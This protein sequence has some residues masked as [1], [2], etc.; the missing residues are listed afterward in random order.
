[1]K[2][3]KTVIDSH[4]HLFAVRDEDGK[5]YFEAFDEYQQRFGLKAI[6]ICCCTICFDDA[7]NN[8]LAALYKL[9][10]PTAF[11][12]GSLVYS[13]LPVKL[14]VPKGM[15]AAT[16]YDE[17]R[18]IGFDGIKLIETKPSELKLVDLP[19]NSKF[20]DE[21]FAKAEQ[22]GTH[23]IWHV[24]DPQTNWDINTVPDWAVR[25]GWYYGD[26]TYPTYE[27]IYRQVFDVLE[28]YPRLNVTFAHFFFLSDYPEELEKI[29]ERFPNVSIDLVP[30]SEM[31]AGINKQHERYR[32]FFEK[33]ADRIVYGTDITFLIELWN[34]DHL[35]NEVYKAVATDKNIEIYSVECKGLDL[36]NEV[37][38]KILSQNFNKKC[39]EKP[40][41][42][43]VEALK[44]YIK[45]YE[46]LIEKEETKRFIKEYLKDL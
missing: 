28:K 26:G 2:F 11:A 30:G 23:F 1:M 20:Y 43:N 35:A 7:G 21:F 22:D 16:Q 19:I 36:P 4:V 17:L 18:E 9:H 5:H 38:Q 10:N 12:Y 3:E 40:R 15:D 14:P 13:E 24:S 31:Y 34:W 29:F 8:I 33:Y 39:N 25:E 45:K 6:N 27:E 44:R 37:C 41:E 32:S 46:H 42:I